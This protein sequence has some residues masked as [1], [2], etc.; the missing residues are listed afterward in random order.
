[1]DSFLNN[2]CEDVIELIVS[3]QTDVKVGVVLRIFPINV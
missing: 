1:M 3:E 2:H